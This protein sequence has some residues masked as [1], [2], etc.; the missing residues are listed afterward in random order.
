MKRELLKVWFLGLAFVGV[1]A[2]SDSDDSV[3]SGG[4]SD[5]SKEAVVSNYSELVLA[6]Y[7]DAYNDA[8]L[9]QVALEALVAL[10][11]EATFE[12][13]KGA[14]LVARESYGQTEAFRFSNGPIDDEDGPEGLLNAWP[15]D[16]NYIDYVNNDTDNATYSNGIINNTADYPT[17]SKE[18]LESLN[19]AVN[20]KSVS[21]GYHAIEFLLWGQ[22]LTDASEKQSGLRAYTDY[23]TGDEGTNE[24]QERRGDYLIACS[25]L[26]IDHLQLMLNEW[27][28]GGDYY[29][30]FSELEEDVAIGNV[31]SGIATFASGELG[32]ERISVAYNLVDQENEHSCFSDNTD[33]DIRLNLKGIA[34]VLRGSYGNVSGDSL[35]DLITNEDAVVG[36]E[37]TAALLNAE[38]AMEATA[39]PFDFAISDESTRPVVLEAFNELVILGDAI[40]AG[41][42]ALG[43]TVS[44]ELPE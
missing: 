19:E 42:G 24:N 37:L 23:V 43:I 31:L 2:C 20:E 21:I 17:I 5:I 4:D 6:N 30:E 44:S 14:W 32:G 27:A 10:P 25:E 36:A 39:T 18:L 15:I 22:D 11:T 38:I 1:V 16:E 7:Q 8:Q 29:V 33:R 12:A 9:L 13:A 34:N 3:A 26:L 40:V 41:A 35:E 28:V